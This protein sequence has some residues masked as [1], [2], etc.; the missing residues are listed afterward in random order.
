MPARSMPSI[1]EAL[2]PILRASLVLVQALLVTARRGDGLGAGEKARGI[3]QP[4]VA[5][6]LRRVADLA[7]L[8]GVV[9][10][11]EQTQVVAQIE[12]PL[13]QFG[14]LLGAADAGERVGEPEAACQEDTF[15]GRV[16]RRRPC[17]GGNAAGT[18]RWSTRA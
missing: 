14:G 4:D 6:C 9:L 3:D 8:D 7:V 18:R 2:K 5:E 11:A 1:L 15:A 16:G 12:Q 13:E 10:L 17:R